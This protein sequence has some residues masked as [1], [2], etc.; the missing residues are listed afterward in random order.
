[1]LH[2]DVATTPR[3]ASRLEVVLARSDDDVRDAQR[4]RW[5]VFHDEQGAVL[6]S[7]EHGLDIDRLD[8]HCE[9][10]LVRD[11]G[12]DRVVGTYRLLTADAARRAGGYYSEQEFVFEGNWIHAERCLELGRSC[13]H[14]DHRSGAVIA[15]LWSGLSAFLMRTGHTSL[16]G[17]ASI[18]ISED[19]SAGAALAHALAR[20]HAGPSK[21][22]VA[23]RRSLR[24]PTDSPSGVGSGSGSGEVPPLLKGYLRSGASVC[25]AP[26]WDP[27]FG[28]AD[29]LLRLDVRA[30]EARYARRFFNA[31]PAPISLQ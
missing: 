9:H 7:P 29:L 31:S 8:D 17:C 25:G 2:Q 27:A 24:L 23:P 11:V 13:V 21:F 3:K 14:A 15:L 22:H 10:L 16:I 12:T 26:Y 6:Q 20:S 4:L 19:S 28:C 18:P 5:Q 1:M 30:I